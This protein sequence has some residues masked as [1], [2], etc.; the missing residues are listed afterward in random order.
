MC[1]IY[2]LWDVGGKHNLWSS[3]LAQLMKL[4]RPVVRN[5]ATANN[6]HATSQKHGDW[7]YTQ[8]SLL[9]IKVKSCHKNVK[10]AW[11][12]P[13]VDL[14]IGFRYIYMCLIALRQSP[15]IPFHLPI[16]YTLISFLSILV[17]KRLKDI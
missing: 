5:N 12:A 8:C 14:L 3:T 13:M 15:G 1:E 11:N 7:L 16:M 2:I 10:T 9:S 6:P 4:T 17:G